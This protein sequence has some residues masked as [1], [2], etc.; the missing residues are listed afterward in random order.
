M[1][2]S[3][4]QGLTA[5]LPFVSEAASSHTQ[6][7]ALR[8]EFGAW[9]RSTHPPDR[10]LAPTTSWKVSRAATWLLPVGCRCCL[11]P[12]L[13]RPRSGLGH[14]MH[15][16]KDKRKDTPVGRG[17]VLIQH[18]VQNVGDVWLEWVPRA[19]VDGLLCHLP[20]GH[21]GALGRQGESHHGC[22]SHWAA[23]G[24]GGNCGGS[25]VGGHGRAGALYLLH[26]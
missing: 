3:S 2:A 12:E 9:K 19:G 1:T 25:N 23:G 7:R 10:H 15:R 5:S 8:E 13:V 18:P 16:Q 24:S 26:C 6:L 11:Q 14:L 22:C 21:V 20:K 4:T 17:E